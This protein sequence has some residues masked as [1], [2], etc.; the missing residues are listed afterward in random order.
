ML[1]VQTRTLQCLGY[2]LVAIRDNPDLFPSGLTLDE[3]AYVDSLATKIKAI[4]DELLENTRDS[5]AI[6]VQDL[7]LDYDRYIKQTL[8]LQERLKE[9]LSFTTGV[10]QFERNT[11]DRYT[12][13]VR[14]YY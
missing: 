4:D 5:M 13:A 2:S 6:K 11:D 8:A 12:F 9:E 3:L 7:G 14:N 10:V 1:S